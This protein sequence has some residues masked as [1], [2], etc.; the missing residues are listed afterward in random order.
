MRAIAVIRE[1][2]RSFGEDKVSL[3]AASLAYYTLLSIFPLILGLL[4]VASVAFDDPAARQRLIRGIA[5]QFPGSEALVVTTVDDLVRGRGAAGVVATLGLIWSA[6]GIFSALTAALDVIW[7]VPRSRGLIQSALL[8][9]GLVFGVGLIFV[10]SLLLGTALSIATSLQV[11][12]VG[13]S[14]SEL[15][16]LLPLLSLVLPLLITFL[17][18]ASIY[19][20]VPNRPLTWS[21]SWPGAVLASVLF[22]AGKD[23]FV[24]YLSTFA[25]L[26]AVYGS[27]GTVIALLIWSYY[28][29]IMLLLGAE[30]N[31]TLARRRRAIHP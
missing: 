29:A 31:A 14:L 10:V 18:T 4:A 13:T 12:V 2:I 26:N 30:L 25:H 27:I 19:R 7:K 3:L 6:S 28:A 17:V 21:I 16:L 1:T 22:E 9:I 5:A 23:V 15:P 20:Y 8:A 24:W 11:P